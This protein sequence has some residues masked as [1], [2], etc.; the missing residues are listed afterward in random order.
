MPVQVKAVDIYAMLS[1]FLT[2][3]KSIEKV[4]VYPSDYG[5]EKMAEEARFGPIGLFEH[6]RLAERLQQEQQSEGASVVI[7]RPGLSPKE[8][9][10]VLETLNEEASSDDE[11]ETEGKLRSI[12]VS[13]DRAL[14][15]AWLVIFE[16]WL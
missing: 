5:L 16:Q 9:A 6:S 1:S 7:S 3:G 15:E 13:C 4:T 14:V 8:R 11:G 12:T 10:A 2:G